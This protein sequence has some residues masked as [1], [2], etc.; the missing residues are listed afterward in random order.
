MP[1]DLTQIRDKRYPDYVYTNKPLVDIY[2]GTKGSSKAAKVLLGE[3]LK[4]NTE[5]GRIP[6]TK[7][8]P[9]LFRGGMGHVSTED[10]TRQ[11]KLEMYFI[12]VDQGDSILIQTPDD[13]RI[14]IDGGKSNEALDFIK[15]KY[16]LDKQGHYIDFDAVVATHSDDDHI[17][18]LIKIL[19][20]PKIAVK[21]LYHNGLFRRTESA[22][23][24][25]ARTASNERV[26]GLE[27]RPDVED[28]PE[29]KSLM[30]RFLK[31]ID[32]AE[33][34]LPIVV[35]KMQE[36]AGRISRIDLPEEGFICQRLER[37]NGCLPPFDES[38][39]SL[40]IEVLWP[41]AEK[42]GGKLS[43]PWFS[44]AGQ[45][46]NGNSIVLRVIHGKNTILLTGDLNEPS[47]ETLLHQL[48]ATV[49]DPKQLTA[50][51]YKAAHHGSQHFLLE[52][53]K[54][55]APNAAVISSG[56]ARNDI[57]GHPRAVLMG[58]ITRYSHHQ[59][60]AVF[61]TEL[62]ACY[63]KLPKDEMKEFRASTGQLY[64]RALQG[65]VHLRSD[66]EQLSLATVHGRK[67]IGSQ[68]DQT[69]WKWDLW[70]TEVS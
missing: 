45:T 61:C 68:L 42:T 33:E 48:S 6:S 53:L 1:E 25:G 22:Q 30:K 4:I 55:V 66:G 35:G 47:M 14:L 10:L 49:A 20:H 70:P 28:R 50:D 44:D 39:P 27:D 19:R 38:N 65:I 18:G 17:G 69:T 5:D 26:F 31:A 51:V 34:N 60:P 43:Y 21:R 63:T 2:K 29:L 59:T 12:D 54:V 23:D 36:Q 58:T 8:V 9:V 13:R 57:H 16:R 41:R 32:K 24:P 56:D 3:W 7:R 64:E 46:V 52:F 67:P 37:A 15:N 11:R 40:T 62:A